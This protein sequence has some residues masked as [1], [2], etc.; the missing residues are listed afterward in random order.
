MSLN[1]PFRHLIGKHARRHDCQHHVALAVDDVQRA[2]FDVERGFSHGFAQRWVRMAG[3]ADVFGA[4]AEFNDRN[5]FG[6]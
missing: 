5:G 3:A 2:F 6:D 4:P 1:E